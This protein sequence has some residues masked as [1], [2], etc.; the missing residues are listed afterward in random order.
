M[1]Q[2][3]VSDHEV[4]APSCFV[5][6][7]P[8]VDRL[9]FDDPV[10][11]FLKTEPRT[12]E[13]FEQCK[14][15][16]NHIGQT[17][18]GMIDGDGKVRLPEYWENE[19]FEGMSN[20]DIEIKII[21]DQG[22]VNYGEVTPYGRP[23][24]IHALTLMK[25]IFPDTDITPVLADITQLSMAMFSTGRKYL[26]LL[27][28]QDAGKSSTAARLIFIYMLVDPDRTFA[29]VASPFLNTSETIIW[30]DI[31]ELYDQLV[32]AH[33]LP[34]PNDKHA[35]TMFPDAFIE[36]GNRIRFTKKAKG[37]TGWCAIRNL[38]K[39]GVMIGVKGVGSDPRSGVGF[40]VFDEIN[41]AENTGFQKDL[42]NIS[43]QDFFQMQSTQNPLDEMD[44]GGMMAEPKVWKGWGHQSYDEVREHSPVLWPT[45][46]S[47]LAYRLNG[48]D[49][50]NI[51]IG[52]IVYPYQFSEKK[53]QK[54][55][56]DY[57]EDS[58]EYYSQCLAMFPGGDVDTRLLSQSR[59]AASKHEDEFFT[60][61]EVKGKVEFCDPAHTGQGDKACLGTAEFGDGIVTNTD[62]SQHEMPLFVVRKPMEHIKF[63]N[64]FV[65]EESFDVESRIMQRMG[66]VG[67]N[68]NDIT[69]GAP[70]TYEQQIALR[71]IERA[72]EE[73]IPLRN[74]GYDFS[75]RPEMVSAVDLI[76]GR[77]PVP[78]N[79]NVKAIGY[80]LH[81]TKENTAERCPQP[82]GRVFELGHLTADLFNSKQL[83]GG[84]HIRVAII[85]TCQTRILN[86][87]PHKPFEKK[88]DFKA[89]NENRSP[90][91]RDTLFGKVGMAFMRGFR[92]VAANNNRDG[93]RDSVFRRSLRN[94]KGRRKI[95]KRFNYG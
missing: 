28:S 43:A 12:D 54:L 41:K 68:I 59:V 1:E 71:M 10:F 58:P 73:G 56:D 70:I 36:K 16:A 14:K 93:N 91:E 4:T 76:I 61:K 45:V 25:L 80:D 24:Y 22:R 6:F 8:H 30:G 85:Q 15:A 3:T 75:M 49:S 26:H 37:K 29:T 55:I 13:D 51:R 88:P 27:G 60:M 78:F 52:R 31:V 69:V 21:H 87:K 20:I 82:H 94:G 47:G 74:I 81:A 92:V 65:W 83:R 46:K 79:Y 77:E 11:A 72:R 33:P 86:D 57:G 40:F 2:A 17:I 50:V 53:R 19:E 84:Q 35:P 32:E 64:N 95:G 18:L 63:I 44:A 5:D 89:R 62:G 39:Q 23:T 7:V 66:E 34:P 38:K 42:A 9:T 48:L 90:D 67:V